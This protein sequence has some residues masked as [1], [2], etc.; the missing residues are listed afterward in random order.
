MIKLT[1]EYHKDCHN[2]MERIKELEEQPE[3]CKHGYRYFCCKCRRD[4][5]SEIPEN[6]EQLEYLTIGNEKIAVNCSRYQLQNF[7]NRHM[8][9][10]ILRILKLLD[11][12]NNLKSALTVYREE[13]PDEILEE[14]IEEMINE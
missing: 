1:G 2:L 12:N 9:K 8:D 5:P 3:K 7:I 11:H 6:D 4:K 10:K 13:H 14:V